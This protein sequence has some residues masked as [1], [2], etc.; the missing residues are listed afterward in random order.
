MINCVL[1]KVARLVVLIT[2]LVASNLF[3]ILLGF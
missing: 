3:V 1:A 2:R